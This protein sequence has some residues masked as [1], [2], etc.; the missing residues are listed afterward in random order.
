MFGVPIL[1]KD[2]IET[3]GIVTAFGSEACKGYVPER[4]ATLVTKLKDAGA[5]ILGK[6]TMPDWAASWFS[7]SSLSDTTKNPFDPSR[8][9][10][11]SSSGSGAA[12]A[13][14]MAVAAIGGDTGGSIR[15]PSS[16]C[17][18]VGIRVTP[19]RI[20]RDG[21]SALVTPQDT[22][23]P[24]VKSVEDAAKIL[25]VI[26]GFDERDPYTS[27]NVI[28]PL[29]K[30]PTPFQDAIEHPT[31]QE[32]RFGVL[33]QA[34]GNEP[35]I[36]AVLDSTLK[37]LGRDGATLVDVEIPDLEHYKTFTSAYV[38]RS[39]S[40]INRFLAE[41]QD[42]SHR[43]VEEL[44]ASGQYHKALDLIDAF[45]QGPDDFE[46]DPHFSK[47]LLEQS[48]FQRIVASIFAKLNLDAIIYPTC[49]L[50]PPKTK[51]LL[52]GR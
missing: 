9:P 13:S 6:T 52:D 14:G 5:V 35:G 11:G 20:S 4:D 33:R 23:G 26:V 17:Q 7:T 21:M 8:D 15:L 29:K 51:N 30:S 36:L 45:V 2:Q 18:L 25:D 38:T 31:I 34:F 42:L 37:K 32:K 10:G 19:G 27:V 43:K 41:R 1:I 28:A 22:P 3:E 46:Q 49:Q 47:R 24:M 39:K 50:L 12:V 16:F 40:D 44:H 48:K